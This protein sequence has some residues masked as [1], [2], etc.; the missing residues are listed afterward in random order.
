MAAND[1]IAADERNPPETGVMPVAM[2]RVPN[3]RLLLI[4]GGEARCSGARHCAISCARSN[5]S[6]L[7]KG[8]H[9]KT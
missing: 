3:G 7:E 5:R 1:F 6:G 8:Q 2:R 9:M 4:L